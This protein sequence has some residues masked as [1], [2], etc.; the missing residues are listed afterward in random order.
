LFLAILAAISLAGMGLSRAAGG[1]AILYYTKSPLYF[2]KTLVGGTSAP[3]TEPVQNQGTAPLKILSIYITGA[4]AG[5]FSITSGGGSQTLAPNATIQVA[6]VF[7]PTRVGHHQAQLDFDSNDSSHSGVQ[8]LSVDLEADAYQALPA[9]TF[10][11]SSLDFGTQAV[12]TLGQSRTVT[13]TNTGQAPLEIYAVGASG[14]NPESFV[15]SPDPPN[16]P[17]APGASRTIKVQ[18]FPY[19]TGSLHAFL[20]IGDNAPGGTHTVPLSGMSFGAAATLEPMTLT[21]IPPRPLGTT[22]PPQSVTLTNVGNQPMTI[23]SVSVNSGTGGIFDVTGGGS[24]TLAPG[25]S[26]TF[27]VTF[28]PTIVGQQQTTLAVTDNA[29]PGIQLV[30]LIGYGVDTTPPPPSPPPPSPPPPPPPP[31]TPPRGHK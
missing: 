29:W 31:R 30:G 27:S 13:V 21:F 4:D 14:P 20:Q 8:T 23:S 24:S 25:A 12:H 7:H 5:S 1:S 9:I 26:E 16:T 11:P 3:Q 2:D 28:T 10:S 17:L 18:F 19:T 22:S 15:I 6:V